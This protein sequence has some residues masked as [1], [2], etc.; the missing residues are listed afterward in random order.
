MNKK[1]M[2]F[3]GWLIVVALALVALYYFFPE[4]APS[5][6]QS[7]NDGLQKGAETVGSYVGNK[8]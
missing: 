7:V 8:S 3:I 2:T 4:Q 1:G 6:M 5:A